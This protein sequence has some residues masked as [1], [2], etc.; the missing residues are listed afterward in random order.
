M[1]LTAAQR[2]ARAR[3]AALTRSATEDTHAMNAKARE[4]FLD[5]FAPDD[6]GL[7]DAERERRAVAARRAYFQGLAQKSAAA[8]R[9]RAAAL[10]ASARTA[11]Q[12]AGE[13]AELAELAS[14][15]V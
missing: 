7:S 1:T 8:R 2:S 10:T 12:L 15:S 5:S 13:L 3:K 11:R 4:T 14:E 9:A 6:P